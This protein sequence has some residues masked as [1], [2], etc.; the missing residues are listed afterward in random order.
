MLIQGDQKNRGRW[1][2]EIVMKLN[3][4]RDRAV[5]L[6]SIKFG[7]P[8]L[9]RVIQHLYFMEL[10]CNLTTEIGGNSASLNVNAIEYISERTAA[11][12][13]KLQITMQLNTKGN[14]LLSNN[15]CYL[16]VPN[17]GRVAEIFRR[18]RTSGTF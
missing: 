12:A 10:S 13:A 2:I 16:S 5:R 3:R 18:F 17:S 1:N 6:A 14:S 7:K 8:M 4:G 9:E 15:I 11:V